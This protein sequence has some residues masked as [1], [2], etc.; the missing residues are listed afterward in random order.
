MLNTPGCG[1]ALRG[2]VALRALGVNRVGFLHGVADEQHDVERFHQR[3][4][5][6]AWIDLGLGGLVGVARA[7]QVKQRAS[8][9]EVLAWLL[10]AHR[11]GRNGQEGGRR[12]RRR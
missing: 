6:L 11:A 4:A 7:D 10:V 12:V 3:P 1:L 9:V 2:F 5:V 8:A